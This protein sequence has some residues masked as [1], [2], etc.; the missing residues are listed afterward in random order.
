MQYYYGFKSY[1]SFSM[2]ALPAHS[3][4]IEDAIKLIYKEEYLYNNLIFVLQGVHLSAAVESV[5]DLIQDVE[6]KIRWE[7]IDR[8]DELTA[9]LALIKE[10]MKNNA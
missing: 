7:M 3:T 4:E 5:E 1:D 10:V 6:D 9:A 2:I 8:T